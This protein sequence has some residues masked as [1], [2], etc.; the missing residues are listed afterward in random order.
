[1]VRRDGGRIRSPRDSTIRS[2][3]GIII[4]SHTD[5]VIGAGDKFLLFLGILMAFIDM[6]REGG[7]LV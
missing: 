4:G 1:M 7:L 2:N 6:C 3:C 5:N